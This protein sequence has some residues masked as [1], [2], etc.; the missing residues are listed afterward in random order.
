MDKRSWLGVGG[1]LLSIVLVGGYLVMPGA[2]SAARSAAQ[3]VGVVEGTEVDLAF[4]T[5]GSIEEILVKEGDTVQAGQLIAVLSNEELLAKREQALAAYKL[6]EAKLA[7]AKKGV[8]VTS[9]SSSAQVQQAQAAVLAAKAQYDANV[10]G[11]RPE[12]ISQL[13]A[14]LAAATTAKQVAEKQLQRMTQLYNDG[15]V[16]KTSLESAQMQFD[17]AAAELAASQEQLR[18]AQSG[19]RKE[20]IDAAKAQWEQA[21]AAYEQA[22]AGTGQVALRES[23]VHQA[24]AALQQAKGAL[25]EVEAYLNNTRLT[26][27]VAGVI[28]SIAVQKGE[29]VSQGFTVATIQAQEDKFVKFYLDETKLGG[30]K[31][32]DKVKLYVPAL[33]KNVEG[34]IAMVAPAADFAVKKATQELGDRDIRA[35]QVKISLTDKQL[36][37]GYSVEWS[38]EGADSR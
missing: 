25:D 30:I 35:F 6:A 15:A 34:T 13:K 17:Q 3:Q 22:V 36:I 28:K 2:N 4:K 12:E 11:A 8:T 23:D 1:F 5:G 16:A 10:N 29:L 31:A 27:P 21:T 9:N 7:Q 32:G 26:A 38:L 37:P 18:M 24:E 14:K 33:Q 20:A 19:A